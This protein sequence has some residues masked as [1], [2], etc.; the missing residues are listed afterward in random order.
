MP[1]FYFFTIGPKFNVINQ[2]FFHNVLK[3]VKTTQAIAP[4]VF[5]PI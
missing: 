2:A 1:I 4:L 5:T 3:D